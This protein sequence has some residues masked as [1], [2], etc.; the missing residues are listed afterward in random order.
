MLKERNPRVAVL[1]S[2]R[3]PGI[4]ML[5]ND[6]ERG[7]S[8]ELACVITT[9]RELRELDLVVSN[10]VPCIART[11][12]P[13]NLRE[14]EEYDATTASYL[15]TFEVDV[16]VLC[17][18][19]RILTAPMLAAFPGRIINLHDSDLS[20][21][22]ED[23]QRRYAGLRSTFDAI[24]AGERQTCAT[25]H[26]VTDEIDGGP[27][28]LRTD[29]FPVSPLAGDALLRGSTDVL[30][31]YAYAHRE[32]VIRAAWGP[33]MRDALHSVLSREVLPPLL[34]ASA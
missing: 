19:L 10:G 32:W 15:Q 1:C 13:A 9:N 31:A 33:L 18:Y 28:L 27:I 11:P 4:E 16:V 2:D 24:A 5:L 21:L 30:K 29:P 6:P 26:Y 34:Q 20:I 8:Y 12:P 14:R 23:G 7:H 22:D 17:C 25:A 3:A